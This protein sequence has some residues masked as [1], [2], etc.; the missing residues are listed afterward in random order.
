MKRFV[1]INLCQ[2]ETLTHILV[3]LRTPNSLKNKQKEVWHAPC[4]SSFY[5]QADPTSPSF[6]RERV[7]EERRKGSCMGSWLGG[8]STVSTTMTFAPNKRRTRGASPSTL[9]D[10]AIQ[11][12]RHPNPIRP[13]FPLRPAAFARSYPHRLRHGRDDGADGRDSGRAG[14]GSRP[15]MINATLL[16]DRSDG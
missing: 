2:Y 16:E 10:I 14:F 13:V 1:P 6:G 7:A 12:L 9:A 8:N 11:D 15:Q 4:I 3:G 5:E